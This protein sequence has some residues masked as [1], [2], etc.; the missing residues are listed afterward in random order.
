MEK[1]SQIHC[2][3]APGNQHY[4]NELWIF[5]FHRTGWSGASSMRP[6]S[7]VMCTVDIKYKNDYLYERTLYTAQNKEFG[8]IKNKIDT[9]N[10]ME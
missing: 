4:L 7:P 8:E 6:T 9:A 2:R 10:I 5:T 1:V 3:A